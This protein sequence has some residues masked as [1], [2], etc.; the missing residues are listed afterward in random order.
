LII[1]C[2]LKTLKRAVQKMMADVLTIDFDVNDGKETAR[3]E[4]KPIAASR[5]SSFRPCVLQKQKADRQRG[6]IASSKATPCL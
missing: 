4:L 5:R 3:D 1:E 6:V 2:F